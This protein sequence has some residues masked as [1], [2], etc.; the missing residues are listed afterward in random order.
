MTNGLNEHAVIGKG[1]IIKDL[2]PVTAL[3]VDM[4]TEAYT[5]AILAPA[6][7][8]L[9]IYGAYEK[10]FAVYPDTFIRIIK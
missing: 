1:G 4:E 6:F 8:D 10:L 5:N 9:Q 7:I 3:P 2:L